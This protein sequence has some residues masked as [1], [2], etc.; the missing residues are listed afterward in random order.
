MKDSKPGTVV[1]ATWE[2]DTGRIMVQGQSRQKFSE[3]LSQVICQA[4]WHASV[5]SANLKNN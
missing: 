3:S 5:I 1:S 2:E 4:W